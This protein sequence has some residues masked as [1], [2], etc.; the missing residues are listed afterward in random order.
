MQFFC[1]KLYIPITII[2]YY[3]L[4]MIQKN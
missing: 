1:A 2:L 3:I 4:F